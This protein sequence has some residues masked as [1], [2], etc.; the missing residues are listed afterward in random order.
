MGAIGSFLNP[1]AQLGVAIAAGTTAIDITGGGSATNAAITKKMYFKYFPGFAYKFSATQTY[2]PV[3]ETRYL[4]IVNP[5]NA[6]V[7]PG[8]VGMYAY[9]TGNNGN[10]ITITARLGSAASGVRVTT[11]GDVVWNTGSWLG[12]HTDVHPSNALII[13]CNSKGV[14]IGDTLMLGRMAAMR[15]YGK[16]RGHRSQDS[17]EG[18]FVTQ[19]F[20]TSVFGQVI[21]K[22]RLGRHPAVMRLRHAIT[23]P[24]LNL[25]VIS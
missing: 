8:K 21:R 1:K 17:R 11:L 5:S 22:D 18:G 9:T 3:S 15:G 23:Y 7:D 16:Y 2:S 20:I 24:H 13:P 14:P 4:L 25:P 6:A 10:K 19:R 12:R